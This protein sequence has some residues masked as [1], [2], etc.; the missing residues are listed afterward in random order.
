MDLTQ[1]EG[2]VERLSE[3]AGTMPAYD[4][5]QAKVQRCGARLSALKRMDD[6][7]LK[8]Y[9]IDP[10]GIHKL[11]ERIEDFTKQ[12]Q[13]YGKNSMNTLFSR[14]SPKEFEVITDEVEAYI[15]IYLN[16]VQ[17]Q[18]HQGLEFQI[19]GIKAQIRRLEQISIDIFQAVQTQT[20]QIQAA[21]V[22]ISQ[23]LEAETR[24]I[25]TTESTE[26]D[27][28]DTT[29]NLPKVPA[30][31][32]DSQQKKPA[33]QSNRELPDPKGI[34]PTAESTTLVVKKGKPSRLAEP[35]TIPIM[36]D[37]LDSKVVFGGGYIS[38][39]ADICM[40]GAFPTYRSIMS[41][42]EMNERYRKIS[43]ENANLIEK[44]RRED[45][46]K[47]EEKARMLQAAS[48]AAMSP[49]E[50]SSTSPR[51]PQHV[52]PVPA[53]LPTGTSSSA[54]EHGL[55]GQHSDFSSVPTLDNVESNVNGPDETT[56]E[57]TAPLDPQVV[58]GTGGDQ[59]T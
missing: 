52:E 9:G 25:S 1:L 35:L 49:G 38:E 36:H 37:S 18:R 23:K 10:R 8:K 56:Q 46:I 24:S 39:A 45:R 48:L 30:P 11:E 16:A 7:F 44:Q 14:P 28:T 15:H 43:E 53:L 5:Q 27:S 55:A 19:Q 47:R 21:I 50:S 32:I 42:G 13:K 17:D 51:N 26:S 3:I 6:P 41:R 33:K 54:G 57:V 31:L 58:A 40:P 29:L 2:L 12:L 59:P 22:D 4:T 20:S 34:P